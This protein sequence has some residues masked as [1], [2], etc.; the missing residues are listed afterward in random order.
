MPPPSIH[1][2][3]RRTR[4]S[5]P[6]RSPH[7]HFDDGRRTTISHSLEICAAAG[8]RGGLRDA[9]CAQESH[10]ASELSHL[11]P[12]DA[13]YIFRDGREGGRAGC[14]A[15][16]APLSRNEGHQFNVTDAFSGKKLDDEREM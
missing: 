16:H 6:I 5:D 12:R 2:R 7:L 8:G 3:R 14:D 10:S 1:R 9:G 4:R 11:S 15:A 13:A